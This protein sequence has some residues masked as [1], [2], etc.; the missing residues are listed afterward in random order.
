M[1]RLA[2]V[3]APVAVALALLP[4]ACSRPR[5][6]IEARPALWR[7]ADADT[8][9]WLLGS[10]HALPPEVR[11]QTPAVEQAIAKADTLVLEVIPADPGDARAEFLAVAKRDGLPPLRERV[12]VAD[13]GVLERGMAVAGQ[14]PGSLDGFKTWAAALTISA[15]AGHASDASAADGV[16]AVLAQRFAGKAIGALETPAGQFATFD[17]LPQGSQQALLM[18]AASDAV[19]PSTGYAMLLDAWTHGNETTLATS[20][21]SSRANPA[22]ARTLVTDRNARWASVIVRRLDRP[23]HVLVAVGA[24]HLVGAESVVAMLRARGLPVERIE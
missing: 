24:G 17:R 18:Q 4:A 21:A 8:T 13:R 11:W 14:S 5:P 9:I 6:A 10:I 1:K 20:V 3:G 22:I 12:A 15:G 16:E 23:G 19:D 7:V 2:R